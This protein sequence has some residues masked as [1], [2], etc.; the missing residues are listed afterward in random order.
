MLLRRRV[1]KATTIAEGIGEGGQLLV[2]EEKVTCVP[3]ISST[4]P[5][6]MVLVRVDSALLDEYLPLLPSVRT[7]TVD[8][9]DELDDVLVL[10]GVAHCVLRA[11]V[12]VCRL[13]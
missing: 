12:L 6:V 3:Q 5:T 4:M 13:R 9:A 11:F 8:P 7:I 2:S 1:T 10:L